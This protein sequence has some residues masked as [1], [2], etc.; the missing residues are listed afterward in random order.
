MLR[1][2]FRAGSEKGD[3]WTGVRA[4][5]GSCEPVERDDDGVDVV[6]VA[7]LSAATLVP[8]LEQL[9]AVARSVIVVD[10]SAAKSRAVR[11]VVDRFPGVQY[12]AP[13]ANLGFAA[14]ANLGAK[15]ATSRYLVFVNPDCSI[16]PCSLR[17]L[18]SVLREDSAMRVVGPVL[19]NERGVPV[20][21]GGTV[22]TAATAFAYASG[23]S[24]L[25]PRLSPWRLALPRSTAK[26]QVVRWVAGTCLAVRRAD[27]EAVGG[28]D[29]RFFLYCE[30]VD[31]CD[32]LV[33]LSGGH[34]AIIANVIAFHTPQTSTP[35]DP[36]RMLRLHAAAMRQFLEQR[37]SRTVA[38]LI[39]LALATGEVRVA[40]FGRL[41]H[42]RQRNRRLTLA[43]A[44]Y[45]LTAD[46]GVDRIHSSLR[47]S[48]RKT[49]QG[50]PPRR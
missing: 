30:D 23:V 31:F 20:I 32:R 13:S 40:I 43:H 49:R 26:L 38:T 28:F 45:L 19:L 33:T 1:S 24:G 9:P 42:S 41:G 4:V 6:V 3:R 39:R 44:R 18:I 14:A 2:P 11:S 34:N 50:A 15:S 37:H 8:L 7:Y 47:P 5:R 17:A 36:Q 35:T 12:V 25:L 46:R 10:N 22:P 29:E 48:A 16:S 27:F 21:S